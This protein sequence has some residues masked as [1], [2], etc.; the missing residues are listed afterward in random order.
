V[1]LN[2]EMMMFRKGCTHSFIR[3]NFLDHIDTDPELKSAAGEIADRYGRAYLI[4]GIDL[5]AVADA[6]L[7]PLT[8]IPAG[9]DG[10][11]YYLYVI[12]PDRPETGRRPPPCPP[13]RRPL[14]TD[15]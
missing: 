12:A 11:A 4:S 8:N 6:M 15:H 10:V 13:V 5:S 3:W 1:L 9:Y 14:R 2:R 7:K